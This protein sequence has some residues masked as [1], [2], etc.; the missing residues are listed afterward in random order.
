MF[1]KGIT[2]YRKSQVKLTLENTFLIK[3]SIKNKN[4]LY[5]G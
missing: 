2:L 5:D 3:P 4:A 1:N